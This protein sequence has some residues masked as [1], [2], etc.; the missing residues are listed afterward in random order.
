MQ[1]YWIKIERSPTPIALN[2]GA[3]I[4]ARSEDDAR[5]IF[6]LAFGVS[7][8]IQAIKPIS[9]VQDLDQRHVVPNMGNWLRRGVW[10]PLG[11]EHI[12]N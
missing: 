6:V 5:Q 1:P 11:Y 12:S 4:T 3:G 7:H 2:L 10:F 8:R 9:D